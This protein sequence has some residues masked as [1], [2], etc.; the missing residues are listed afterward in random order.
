MNPANLK[1]GASVM[2]VMGAALTNIGYQ[3][4]PVAAGVVG[5]LA[6]Q[7]TATHEALVQADGGDIRWRAD[8]IAPTTGE[9]MTLAAGESMIITGIN[10][11]TSFRF[12]GKTGPA[13]V[14]VT[15]WG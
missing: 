14:S 9:G 1:N 7:D 12:I 11:I 10:A 8:G 6:V 5:Q 15:F 3:L 4:V 13:G 2:R